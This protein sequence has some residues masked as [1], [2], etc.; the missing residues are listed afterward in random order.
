MAIIEVVGAQKCFGTFRALDDVNLQ[1]DAGEV[2]VI[3]GPSG[4]GKSTLLRSINHLEQLS[5]GTVY[6]QG[7]PV[8]E[9]TARQIRQH[10]GMVFQQFE[11][12]P[13]MTVLENCTLGP[14]KTGALKRDQAE[15]LASDWLTR[16][17]IDE[18][19]HTYPAS[20][21]GGQKQRAAIVRALCMQPDVLLFDEPTSALDPEMISE[22]LDVMVDLAREGRTMIIVTHEMGFAR[23][24]ADRVVYMDRGKIIE[25][26]SP[27]PFFANPQN[28]STRHFLSKILK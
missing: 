16:V 1:V 28:E 20:L 11:L 2:V 26:N 14:I 3:C 13:H 12:F 5:G 8:S 9:A 10:L 22:V 4:S 18:K 17:G 25:Q 6:V 19:A 15:S 21:S 7:T 24:V 23:R 27:E